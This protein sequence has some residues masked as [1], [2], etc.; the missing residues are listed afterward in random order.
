MWLW[1][2]HGMIAVSVTAGIMLVMLG[3]KAV[4]VRQDPRS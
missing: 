4:R 3:V 1:N 2:P